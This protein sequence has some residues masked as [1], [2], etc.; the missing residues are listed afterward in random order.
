M[1]K[2][3]TRAPVLPHR[4]VQRWHKRP[5]PRDGVNPEVMVGA[6]FIQALCPCAASLRATRCGITQLPVTQGRMV[7]KVWRTSSNAS[8][9]VRLLPCRWLAQVT[10]RRM[11]TKALT[12]LSAEISR[13]R[14]WF[15]RGSGSYCG[16]NRRRP[17]GWR[18]YYGKSRLS[19]TQVWVTRSCARQHEMHKKKKKKKKP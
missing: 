6:V 2:T 13:S 11:K 15:P 3:R 5:S 10:M 17:V 9:Q 16:I 1:K 19:L 8:P 7:R 12:R 18:S 4:G 14:L